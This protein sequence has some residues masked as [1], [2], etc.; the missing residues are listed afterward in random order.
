MSI[1]GTALGAPCVVI[2]SAS[3]QTY[4]I[5]VFGPQSAVSALAAINLLRNLLGAFLPLAAPSLYAD[6]GLGWGNSV[7]AFIAVAFVPVP[8]FFYWHGAWLRELFLVG[9]T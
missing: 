1:I 8:F 3:S 9:K 6:L 7:L 4:I 2:V 5:D